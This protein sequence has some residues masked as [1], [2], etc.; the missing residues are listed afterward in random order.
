[1]SVRI[2]I[3]ERYLLLADRIENWC[4]LEEDND[5]H[6]QMMYLFVQLADLSDKITALT[7][8]D[9]LGTPHVDAIIKE[10]FD[11]DQEFA[12]IVRQL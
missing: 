10:M 4:V 2:T 7:V 12:A 5:E 1:M 11:I 6:F 8:D 3:C 9:V